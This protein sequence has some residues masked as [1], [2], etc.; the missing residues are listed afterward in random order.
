MILK[1]A[2]L[3]ALL[4]AEAWLVSSP[5]WEPAILFIG[6]LSSLIIQEVKDKTVTNQSNTHDKELFTKFLNDLP[7]GEGSIDFLRDHDFHNS[8]K[9]AKLD[10]LRDFARNWD[11]AEF[12]F[13]N[14]ELEKARQDL[15]QTIFQ[16]IDVSSHHTFPERDGWQTSIPNYT[17]NGEIPQRAK[18]SIKKMNDLG[19]NIFA[20]HQTLIRLGKQQLNI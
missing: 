8:F 7:S 12:E 17:D 3:I 6:F 20:M 14:K 9:L 1:I 10:Q 19:D 13:L 18:E 5:D 11:N 16:F 4:L 2:N 15:L